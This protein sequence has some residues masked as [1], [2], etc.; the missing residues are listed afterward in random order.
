MSI[1]ML[2]RFGSRAMLSACAAMLVALPVKADDSDVF[3]LLTGHVRSQ[4]AIESAV[5]GMPLVGAS[6]MEIEPG[7]YEE[8]SENFSSDA[9]TLL[10]QAEEVR[11]PRGRQTASS[12]MSLSR[13]LSQ[14]SVNSAMPASLV[15]ELQ[16]VP[17]NFQINDLAEARF[18]DWSSPR[19][20]A[21]MLSA[22]FSPSGFCWAAP[23]VYHRPLYFEQPNVERYGHYVSVCEG[24]NC[25]QSAVCAAHF[26]GT[27]PV[28]P[29]KVGADPC[30]EKQYV[31]GCYRPGS[32]NP[33]QLIK[34]EVSC[35]GLVL[36]GMTVTGLVFLIP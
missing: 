11:T 2:A 7:V 27:I 25:L 33:H 18:G 31:L 26:F 21:M 14:I 34:P 10:S 24:G 9:F 32:C 13:P 6:A 19:Y 3:E 29:Y 17:P 30:C 28:L 8:S 1:A 20:S 4:P 35:R 12:E 5:E 36:Q 15:E 23:A 16:K 22:G